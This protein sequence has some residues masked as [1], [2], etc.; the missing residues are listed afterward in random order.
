MLPGGTPAAAALHQARTVCRRSEI[1]V[2][3]LT[4]TQDVNQQLLVYLNRLSD[5]LFVLARAANDDGHDDILWVPG[6]QA[7]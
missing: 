7:E 6:Q 1:E 3:R 2:L 4:Q 5:L